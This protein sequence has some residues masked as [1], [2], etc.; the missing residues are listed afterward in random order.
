MRGITMSNDTSSIEY[1]P[2]QYPFRIKDWDKFQYYKF[3]RPPWIR[4]HVSTLQSEDWVMLDDGG[5]L[6]MLSLMMLAS[7]FD[8][9]LPAIVTNPDYLKR[10]L[11]LDHSPNIKPLISHGFLLAMHASACAGMQSHASASQSTETEYRED[12]KDAAPPTAASSSPEKELFARGKEIL[13]KQAGGLI[14]KLLAAKNR[15]VALARAVIEMASTKENP[16]EYIGRVVAGG[17]AGWNG[18]DLSGETRV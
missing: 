10:V 3:R 6:L 13:G 12:K 5:K 16:R 9:H 8:G 18:P 1:P 17:A 7:Q 15:N 4:L 2:E 11:H 14:S